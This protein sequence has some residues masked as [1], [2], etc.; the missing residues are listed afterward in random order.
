MG[1]AD[2]P[3]SHGHRRGPEEG[4]AIPAGMQREAS[5]YYDQNIFTIIIINIHN[6]NNNNTEIVVVAFGP[7]ASHPDN[8]VE[9]SLSHSA[10]HGLLFPPNL[11]SLPLTSLRLPCPG[12]H[13]ASLPGQLRYLSPWSASIPL[14]LISFD[15]A[16]DQCQSHCVFHR[17]ITVMDS[18]R[19]SRAQYLQNK[20]S[21]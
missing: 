10:L 13:H 14:S 20:D 5:D 7:W 2:Q 6:N 12:R 21:S 15:T 1:H 17:K 3:H 16:V 8:Q 18:I 4:L 19:Y 9:S 11:P